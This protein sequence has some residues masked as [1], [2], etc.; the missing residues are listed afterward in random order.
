MHVR[1]AADHG[2]YSLK[3]DVSESLRGAGYEV[4]DFGADEV[5]P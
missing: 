4:M 2:G 5:S 1:I 3:V